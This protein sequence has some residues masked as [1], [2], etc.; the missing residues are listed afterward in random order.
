MMA[1]HIADP[2]TVALVERLA[3]TLKCSKTAAVT[4][5]VRK[6]LEERGQPTDVAPPKVRG[7]LA[8]L[9]A[10]L[11]RETRDYVRLRAEV[12]GK[13]SGTRIYTMLARHGIV[14]TIERLAV[15]GPSD[16][17]RFL[18]EHD[19]LDLATENIVLDETYSHLF[20][21][22]VRVRAKAN[23]EFARSLRGR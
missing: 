6:A 9:E 2:D 15:D 1:I 21:D 5:S 13:R 23:L 11:R 3:T 10:R 17:L 18:A 14:K 16:G 22:E 7:L 19:R 8:N 12:S 4:H 20:S